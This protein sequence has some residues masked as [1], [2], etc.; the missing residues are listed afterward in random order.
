[1]MAFLRKDL[2]QMCKD[3]WRRKE[4]EKSVE[5]LARHRGPTAHAR[6]RYRCFLPDL[7]G[8]AGMRRARPMPDVIDFSIEQFLA[9]D[10]RQMTCCTENR[11]ET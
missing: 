9:R 6:A 3:S 7:A 4:R 1:M 10:K 11:T 5:N 8:L 2:H